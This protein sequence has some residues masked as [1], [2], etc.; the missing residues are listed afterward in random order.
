M[1]TAGGELL[2]NGSAN[3]QP[4]QWLGGHGVLSVE[5]TWGGGNVALQYGGPNGAWLPV[6][7]AQAGT[8]ISLTANGTARFFLPP[9]QIRLAVTTASAVFARADRVPQ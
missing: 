3:S 8:A 5:A 6:E 1:Q 7:N 2:R 9:G 4:M